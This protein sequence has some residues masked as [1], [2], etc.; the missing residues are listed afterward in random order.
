MPRKRR[1][2][3]ADRRP[4]VDDGKLHYQSDQEEEE[5]QEEASDAL[6]GV[7]KIDYD[8]FCTVCGAN[9][10]RLFSKRML[11]RRGRRGE[12]TRRCK[13]C[14]E[15]GQFPQEDASSV[16]VPTSVLHS[17]LAEA[18]S[19]KSA[20]P[21]RWQAAEKAR[22]QSARS[23]AAAVAAASEASHAA[24][25]AQ[26][27]ADE[28]DEASRHP[29]EASRNS[30]ALDVERQRKKLRKQLRL[31]AELKKQRASGASLEATQERKI[32][33]EATLL[34]ELR[35]LEAGYVFFMP[36]KDDDEEEQGESES[37]RAP[38]AVAKAK[39]PRLD[40]PHKSAA[41]ED[42]GSGR[43]PRRKKECRKELEARPAPQAARNPALGS[44]APALGPR[45]ALRLGMPR[46]D[47]SIGGE[48]DDEEEEEEEKGG[49]GGGATEMSDLEYMRSKMKRGWSD[50]DD[51][52]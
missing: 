47:A 14:V 29:E 48:V 2:P 16:F 41:F 11:E 31:I 3:G 52:D 13:Q 44:N 36:D 20:A 6:G 28:G 10:A 1:A 33:R 30:A 51:E 21:S 15:G 8:A 45:P 5:E 26:R 40:A 12:R 32:S 9:D 7:P 22:E 38:A 50:F 23:Y 19:R 42:D 18:T 43:N 4:R 39:R 27:S 24:Q 25:A 17:A 35:T 37:A 46:C 49:G 34:S